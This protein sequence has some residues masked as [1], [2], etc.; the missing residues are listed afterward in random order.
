MSKNTDQVI[1]SVDIARTINLS[2]FHFY[3]VFK[4]KTGFTPIE[5]FNHLKVQKACQYLLF[6]DLRIKEIAYQLGI[7]DPYYFSRLFRKVMGTSPNV[8]TVK[9]KVSKPCDL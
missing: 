9:R 7:D 4:K 2:P 3:S 6:S 5:Y 8:N 1:N